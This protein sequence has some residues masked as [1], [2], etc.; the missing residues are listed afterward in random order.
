MIAKGIPIMKIVPMTLRLNT[1]SDTALT[2]IISSYQSKEDSDD[3]EFNDSLC[4][5]IKS[6]HA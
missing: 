5:L 4:L 1:A 6:K 3:Q 2:A